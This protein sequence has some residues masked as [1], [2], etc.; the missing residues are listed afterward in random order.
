MEYKLN[1]IDIHESMLIINKI[2]KK[3]E[4]LPYSRSQMT[5]VDESG[6]I[7]KIIILL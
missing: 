2:R 1:K 4:C 6:R 3:E 5:N 7:G